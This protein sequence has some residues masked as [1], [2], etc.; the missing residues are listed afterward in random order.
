MAMARTTHSVR[1]A[2]FLTP[3]CCAST[4]TRVPSI[5]E[6]GTCFPVCG[7]VGVWGSFVLGLQ[8]R[9][10]KTLQP[11]VAKAVAAEDPKIAGTGQ[12]KKNAHLEL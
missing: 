8:V 7:D 5:A 11:G 10:S 1:S 4:G 12:W 2:Y 3:T 9:R 6:H